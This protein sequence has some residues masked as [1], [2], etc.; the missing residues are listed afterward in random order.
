[1]SLIAVSVGRN[2]EPQSTFMD[3]KNCRFDFFHDHRWKHRSSPNVKDQEIQ[4]I[5]MTMRRKRCGFRRQ[6]N[7]Q[8][9]LLN[10]RR[11]NDHLGHSKKNPFFGL[12]GS[13]P[14]MMI[15]GDIRCKPSNTRTQLQSPHVTCLKSFYF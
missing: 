5:L 1:M 6:K 12:S 2:C 10:S 9:S 15:L 14:P 3:L 11:T 7:A 8:E 4:V 13:F